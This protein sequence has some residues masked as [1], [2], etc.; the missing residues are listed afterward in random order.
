MSE[1]QLRSEQMLV[2]ANELGRESDRAAA[3][4]AAGYLDHLL[5]ELLA[6]HMVVAQS[7]VEEMLYKNGNGPLGTFSAR[8]DLGYCLGLLSG[9]EYKDL[10]LVRKIRN[11]FAHK[12]TGLSFA[13]PNIASRCRELKGSQVDGQP[14]SAREQFTKASIRLMVDLILRVENNQHGN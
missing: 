6:A 9:D 10:N 1:Q 3:L 8:I 11:D 7:Q 14:S 5:G 12:L 13:T 4:L 2:L